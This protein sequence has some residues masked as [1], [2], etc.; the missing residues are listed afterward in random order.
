M[1]RFPPEDAGTSLTERVR[2]PDETAPVEPEEG[3]TPRRT[4][5]QAMVHEHRIAR[6]EE[7]IMILERALRNRSHPG[8]Q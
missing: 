7:R 6:L 1:R 5:P 8:K 2:E 4:L 3:L